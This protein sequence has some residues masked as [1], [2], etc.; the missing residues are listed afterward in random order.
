M[1]TKY[2]Q[3]NPTWVKTKKVSMKFLKKQKNNENKTY[4]NG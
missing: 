3:Q 1:K 2:T 4:E